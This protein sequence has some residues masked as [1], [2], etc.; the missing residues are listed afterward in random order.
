MK[1][2]R[3]FLLVGALAFT[4]VL[5]PSLPAADLSITAASVIPGARA[6]YVQGQT[7]AGA[8]I[9]AGQ[10]VYLALDGLYKLADANASAATAN[11]V[12]YAANSASTGQFVG[13]VMEDD[14]F[15]VGATLSTAASIYVLSGTAGGI[16]PSAD[17]ASGMYPTVV[18]ISKSTTK[19]IFKITRGTVPATAMF[20][21]F[22]GGDSPRFAGLLRGS[23]HMIMLRRDE[24][25]LELAA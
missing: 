15:T 18:L 14:D 25:E 6:K 5:P 8:T 12:G 23:R 13:V 19:A 24:I 16:A 11:V 10:L 9:T 21:P 17:L 4:W 2:L 7:I 3:S 1:Y 20:V 22:D